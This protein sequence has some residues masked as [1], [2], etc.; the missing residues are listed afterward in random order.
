MVSYGRRVRD[1]PEAQLNLGV[2][3]LHWSKAFPKT[4]PRQ[5]DGIRM[6]AEQGIA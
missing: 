6:A 3:V 4:I 5:C 2:H 1:L